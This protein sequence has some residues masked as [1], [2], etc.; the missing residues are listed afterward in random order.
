MLQIEIWKE[1]K[2]RRKISHD[3]VLKLFNERSQGRRKKIRFNFSSESSLKSGMA[4]REVIKH[5]YELLVT[6]ISV[7]KLRNR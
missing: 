6:S 3:R 1:E 5:I 7:I 2:R 4:L